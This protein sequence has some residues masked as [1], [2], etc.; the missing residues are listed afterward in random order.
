[1]SRFVAFLLVLIAACAHRAP[2]QTPKPPTKLTTFKPAAPI[3]AQTAPLVTL[4]KVEG[5]S[6]DQASKTSAAQ[7]AVQGVAAIP[8]PVPTVVAGTFENACPEKGEYAAACQVAFADELDQAVRALPS[9]DQKIISKI[10]A[11]LARADRHELAKAYYS[12]TLADRLSTPYHRE[13][14]SEVLWIALNFRTHRES[15]ARGIWFW[16]YGT[17]AF[18]VIDEQ[19]EAGVIE[20]L[21]Q[22]GINPYE[23]PFAEA[24]EGRI[25]DECERRNEHAVARFNQAQDYLIERYGQPGS[26]Y[27]YPVPTPAN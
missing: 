20:E 24:V 8:A 18:Y 3:V 11:V 22:R 25:R 12:K 5:A 15:L 4:A 26:P 1:M 13:L 6:S 21:K 14:W 19:C 23:F 27:N 9:K 10:Q 16:D 7:D 17:R 2:I